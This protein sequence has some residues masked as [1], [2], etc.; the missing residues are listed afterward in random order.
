M[1][2]EAAVCCIDLDESEDAEG[3]VEDDILCRA[4]TARRRGKHIKKISQL[5]SQKSGI[6]SRE[7]RKKKKK[8][9]LHSK[10]IKYYQWCTNAEMH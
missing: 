7:K 3:T 5:I 10:F 6:G 9:E 4:H 1:A 8:K 2:A